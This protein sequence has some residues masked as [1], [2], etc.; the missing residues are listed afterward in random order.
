MGIQLCST[1]RQRITTETLFFFC[2]QLVNTRNKNS[3][4][5][6]SDRTEAEVTQVSQSSCSQTSEETP[7]QVHCS[8]LIPDTHLEQRYRGPQTPRQWQS[9]WVRRCS[10]NERP[11]LRSR[12][13]EHRWEKWTQ[14]SRPSR[15][16]TQWVGQ[17]R[18]GLSRKPSGSAWCNQSRTASVLRRSLPHHHH[19]DREELHEGLI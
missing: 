4:G 18:R 6:C 15:S 11:G 19:L 17:K 10:R 3:G 5:N 9:L 1:I 8:E 2:L 12:L 14:K 13:S 7:R 16:S